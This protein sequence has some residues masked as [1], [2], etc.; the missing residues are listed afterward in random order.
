MHSLHNY[1]SANI[2]CTHTHTYTYAHTFTHV[3]TPWPYW[4]LGHSSGTYK[5]HWGRL[6][7]LRLSR[8]GGQVACCRG[9]GS[10]G[11]TQTAWGGGGIRKDRSGNQLIL[12]N[13]MPRPHPSHSSLSLPLPSLHTPPFLSH[14]DSITWYS[15]MRAWRQRERTHKSNYISST[16]SLIGWGD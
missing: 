11:Q 3:Y 16:W 4:A 7:V 14:L 1:E 8:S 6:P 15:N 10:S 9:L 5:G 12:S 2:N 13:N